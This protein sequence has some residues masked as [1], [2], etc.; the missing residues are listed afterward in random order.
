MDFICISIQ[1][2]PTSTIFHPCSVRQAAV[3]LCSF[4]EI[5]A[6]A[7]VP[8]VH[9][10]TN[11]WFTMAALFLMFLL[12]CWR[13]GSVLDVFFQPAH[14][15]RPKN[16]SRFGLGESQS[17]CRTFYSLSMLLRVT[18]A[19]VLASRFLT[20]VYGQSDWHLCSAFW[21]PWAEYKSSELEKDLVLCRAF[22][23]FS[24]WCPTILGFGQR[25]HDPVRWSTQLRSYAFNELGLECN[26]SQTADLAAL[27]SVSE[28]LYGFHCESLNGSEVECYP[29]P[30]P[31]FTLLQED[32]II[33]TDPVETSLEV[34]K[35]WPPVNVFYEC[36]MF[37]DEVSECSRISQTPL[38]TALE[39]VVSK[40][41]ELQRCKST[42]PQWLKAPLNEEE[43][44]F[45]CQ[46][47]HC[48]PWHRSE[49]WGMLGSPGHK[50]KRPLY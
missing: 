16:Y 32:L 34:C 30:L 5:L 45:F 44:F 9:L 47:Q 8:G 31:D 23:D 28:D 36:Q 13:A 50:P 42:L 12:A 20:Y 33:Y 1:T 2:H 15:L 10:I 11:P 3:W 7:S 41:C 18:C 25:C 37:W 22:P 17:S 27:A 49:L 46:C 21:Y 43:L 40:F 24:S 35:S 29:Y 6:V 26:S 48:T 19:A 39:S 4:S 38:R 14:L